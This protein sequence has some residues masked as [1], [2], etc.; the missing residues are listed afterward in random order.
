LTLLIRSALYHSHFLSLLGVK[1]KNRKLKTI[2]LSTVAAFA[3]A[4]TVASVRP[5]AA[6]NDRDD[7]PVTANQLKT[8]TPIKHLVV[9]FNENR[10]FDHY[11]GTYPQAAN[12]PGQPQFTAAKNTPIPN[13]YIASPE[14]KANLLT[15]N[16]NLNLANNV[17]E[18]PPT[19]TSSGAITKNGTAPSIPSVPFRLDRTQANTADQMA[20]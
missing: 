13:N 9:I 16:P 20:S 14:V 3:V 11:F 18:V 2:L 8:K 4:V 1:M 15:H 19:L 17:A 10:S 12:P 6:D 5:V 7:K